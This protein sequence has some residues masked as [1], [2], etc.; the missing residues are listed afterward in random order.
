MRQKVELARTRFQFCGPAVSPVS[1]FSVS[2]RAR[3]MMSTLLQRRLERAEER[4]R[5]KE[6]QRARR[7]GETE[8]GAHR[9]QGKQRFRGL[10]FLAVQRRR[11]ERERDGEQGAGGGARRDGP[12]SSWT[13]VVPI[14]NAESADP[15][16]PKAT[17]SA[18]EDT[19]VMSAGADAIHLRRPALSSRESEAKR[20]RLMGLLSAL[21]ERREESAEHEREVVVEESGAGKSRSDAWAQSLLFS[22]AQQEPESESLLFSTEAHSM[23]QSLSQGGGSEWP[24]YRRIRIARRP[25]PGAPAKSPQRPS[26]LRGA[27]RTAEDEETDS[28][29]F[30]STQPFAIG[31]HRKGRSSHTPIAPRKRGAPVPAAELGS[32]DLDLVC[33]RSRSAVEF[34]RQHASSVTTASDTYDG[35]QGAAGEDPPPS[36]TFNRRVSP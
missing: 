24:Q 20:A 30:L 25:L 12:L 11:L 26:Q 15:A 3:E 14:E 28:A 5:Q 31:Q 4:H 36:P 2:P 10:F 29:T 18:G 17:T 22:E 19:G 7:G 21:L 23:P 9:R 34:A 32:D 8:D 16:P 1:Q 33:V 27:R 13:G 6:A 35:A